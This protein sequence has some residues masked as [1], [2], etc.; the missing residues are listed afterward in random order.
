MILLFLIHNTGP[1]IGL[2]EQYIIPGKHILLFG[3][4]LVSGTHT[5]TLNLQQNF[6]AVQRL[7]GIFVLIVWKA[8]YGNLQCSA[9][10]HYL[11]KV[12]HSFSSFLLTF[13]SHVL[14]TTRISSV[15]T[16]GEN[17]WPI[18]HITQKPM[19]KIK[20]NWHVHIE[21]ETKWSQHPGSLLLT[22]FLYTMP[23]RE[24]GEKNERALWNSPIEGYTGEIQE[25]FSM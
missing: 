20:G 8:S 15:L 25:C 5:Y 24:I 9:S 22:V 12:P 6:Q 18:P 3:G 10:L 4:K 7:V 19:Y 1:L 13:F 2:L 21:C 17:R 16:L 14:L 23:G 11:A